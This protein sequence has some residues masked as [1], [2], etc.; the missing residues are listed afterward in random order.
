MSINYNNIKDLISLLYEFVYEQKKTTYSNYVY[1]KFDY[2]N[3][4]MDDLII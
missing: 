2:S 1:K 3:I 4:K